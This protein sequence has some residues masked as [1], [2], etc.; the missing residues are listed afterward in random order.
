M[1]IDR[2]F[3]THTVACLGYVAVQEKSEGFEKF[4]RY[5]SIPL[6]TTVP[7]SELLVVTPAQRERKYLTLLS[8]T[9][10]DI[11]AH[12][13]TENHKNAR[14][15]AEEKKV[16]EVA[17][18]LTYTAHVCGGE[19]IRRTHP[20]VHMRH[21]MAYTS[22]S[23]SCAD[24]PSIMDSRLLQ[25]QHLTQKLHYLPSPMKAHVVAAPCLC[26]YFPLSL[27]KFTTL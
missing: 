1:P 16:E 2:K 22:K 21:F 6:S 20:H 17:N 3:L 14:R 25:R 27:S 9:L 7:R 5:L 18:S 19:R 11:P 4:I 10:L 15:A 12:L 24:S 23:K 13:L 8:Q 26:P